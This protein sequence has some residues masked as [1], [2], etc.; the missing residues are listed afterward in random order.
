M[1][2]VGHHFDFNNP[3]SQFSILVLRAEV[4]TGYKV[5]WER[6]HLLVKMIYKNT[7]TTL[8]KNNT[9]VGKIR[10]H[11]PIFIQHH[12]ISVWRCVS[13]IT[14]THFVM[15]SHRTLP[16]HSNVLCLY[17][18]LFYFCLNCM[19]ALRDIVICKDSLQFKIQLLP[20]QG[21]CS[22]SLTKLLLSDLCSP[23]RFFL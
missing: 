18:D 14:C 4:K 11:F 23:L 20:S 19:F 7:F 10:S 15:F 21:G 22:C 1:W 12:A 5:I 2:L 6:K 3:W 16:S 9:A 13:L 8:K 17:L